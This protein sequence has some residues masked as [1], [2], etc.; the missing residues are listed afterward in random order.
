MSATTTPQPK[1][2][3]L[4]S[5]L[6][7]FLAGRDAKMTGI[8]IAAIVIASIMVPRFAQARTVSY[9]TLDIVA[10]LLIAL[11]MTLVMVAAD[12]DLSVAST[13]G[14]AS[15]VLGVSVEA[16]LPFPAAVLLCLVIGALCGLF[17]GIMTAYVGLPALAVTIGTLALYRGLALVVIGDRAVAVFPEYATSYV[18]STFGDT[19]IPSLLVPLVI[20]IGLF[21][22]LFD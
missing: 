2:T 6:A 19:G 10:I 8:L 21:A 4:S 12:I 18:T 17:N 16:G 15:A 1:G 3:R 7:R 9:L 22:L 20:L 13:A 5:P 11:P 14:L